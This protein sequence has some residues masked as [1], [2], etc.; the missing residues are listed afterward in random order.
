VSTAGNTA[1]LDDKR[2][3][4]FGNTPLVRYDILNGTA[5]QDTD[6]VSSGAVVPP[7]AYWQRSSDKKFAFADREFND[8]VID[9]GPAGGGPSG[10]CETR[11]QGSFFVGGFNPAATAYFTTVIRNNTSSAVTS[12]GGFAEND[13]GV[14]AGITSSN[15]QRLNGSAEL[16]VATGQSVDY[17]LGHVLSASVKSASSGATLYLGQYSNAGVNYPSFMVL[18]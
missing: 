15:A 6:I 13:V 12:V 11:D 17:T 2:A 3:I 14:C 5:T 16:L 10:F 4:A 8:L 1:W 7:T 9:F 18:P